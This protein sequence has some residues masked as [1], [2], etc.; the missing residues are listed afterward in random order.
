VQFWVGG[1]DEG[2]TKFSSAIRFA[3]WDAL[4][5]ADISMP[6]PQ[7]EVRI[8]GGESPPRAKRPPKT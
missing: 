7:R 5:A 3:V 6:F 4:K 1:L 8:L 2:K